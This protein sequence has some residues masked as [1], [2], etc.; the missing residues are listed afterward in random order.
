[1]SATIA[2]NDLKFVI[3][4]AGHDYTLLDSGKGEKQIFSHPFVPLNSV[5][6]A[7]QYYFK[8][9]DE[10]GDLMDAVKDDLAHCTFTPALG[11]TFDTE[12]EVTVSVNYHREYIYDEETIVVDKTVSQTI[13]VVNHGNI[14]RNAFGYYGHFFCGD[15]YEDGYCFMRPANVNNLDGVTYCDPATNG[16]VTKLSSIYWR[17]EEIGGYQGFISYGANSCNDIDELQYADVSRV[18]RIR[19]LIG[20]CGANPSLEPLK[21]WDV[22]NVTNMSGLF[23]NATE[24]TSLHGLEKWD[25]SN[26]TDLSGAFQ[27]CQHLTDLTPIADWDVSNVTTMNMMFIGSAVTDLSPLAD[28]NVEN[29]EVLGSAFKGL[30]LVSLHGLENWNVGKLHDISETFSGCGLTSLALLSNWNPPVVEAGNAFSYNTFTNLE[31]LENFDT[32]NA[33]SMGSMFG[34]CGKLVSLH[35]IESWDVSN[36]TSM[37]GMFEGCPWIS[38]VSALAG[39]D[40][41]SLETV[42]RMFGGTASIDDVSAF[43]NWDFSNMQNFAGM[44]QG[45]TLFYSGGIDRDVYADAYYYYDYEG[46]RYVHVGLEP[47]TA[48]TKDA[49]DASSWN[50]SGSGLGAFDDK[51]SNVPAW[52]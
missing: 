49:S 3:F 26:V 42:Q 44:F 15:I 19:E 16:S 11:T 28:W 38:D 48:Y 40:T 17:T 47:L 27:T 13:T 30:S 46:N 18:T 35:G 34:Y 32:S 6:Y 9:A 2:T 52:N 23:A 8:V 24:L 25:V 14:T 37:A 5:N 29:L 1:M 43:N 12:G 33:T 20:Y 45:F 41:S 36:V 4:G 10:N 7:G 22:S 31:G 39:W 51:W 21:N 50:V